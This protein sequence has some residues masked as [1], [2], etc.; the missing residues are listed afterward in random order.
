MNELISWFEVNMPESEVIIQWVVNNPELVITVVV[1]II[2]YRF[3]SRFLW[4]VMGV[5]RLAKKLLRMGMMQ[6]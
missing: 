2:L 1:S 6:G 4:R 3:I 5:F